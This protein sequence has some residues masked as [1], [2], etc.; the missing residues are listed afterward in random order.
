ML[1]FTEFEFNLSHIFKNEE[2]IHS[3]KQILEP[4]NLSA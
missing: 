2:T 4:E 3:A 1:A